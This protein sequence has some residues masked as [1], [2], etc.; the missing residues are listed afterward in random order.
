MYGEQTYVQPKPAPA[1]E[2][3][4]NRDLVL[5]VLHQLTEDLRGELALLLYV[6]GLS[7]GE[8]GRRLRLSRQ[9]INKRVKSITDTAQQFVQDMP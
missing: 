1:A 8:A 9:T 5:K 7:Q 6:D 3:I 2:L 4:A